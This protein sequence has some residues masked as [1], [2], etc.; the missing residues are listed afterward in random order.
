M[1]PA[2]TDWRGD[3]NDIRLSICIPV[4][5][6]GAFLGQ[7]LES[8]LGQA[9][10]EVEIVV[11]DGGSTD[12]TPGVV[13]RLQARF[14]RLRYHRL[15]KRGGI[16]RDMARCVD[17]ARGDYCWLLGGDD[18]AR[19]DA[20]PRLLEELRSGCDVYLLESMLCTFEM[21][22]IVKHDMIAAAA[23]TTFR[24]HDRQERIAYFESARNTAAFFSFCSALVVRRSR[25]DSTAVDD[26]FYGTCWAHAARIMAMIP[27][28]LTVRYLPEPFLDK[29]SDN[30]SFLTDGRTPRFGVAVDGYH[31]IADSFFGH[32]SREALCIRRALRRELPVDAWAM[33]KIEMAA[34]GRR[35]QYP[36]YYRLARKQFSDPSFRNWTSLAICHA[37]ASFFRLARRVVTAARGARARLAGP[38]P[39]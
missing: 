6:F 4:Y 32:G 14:P 28:G 22:P 39:A 31:K 9:S 2:I 38:R 20:I 13:Q 34:N 1:L 24:L 11:L 18:L 30:D 27:A 21:R 23:P 36:L 8:V 37:P 16:D 12:D 19:P 15:E 17:L 25:W 29:R 33:A 26:S 10:D 7:T 3:L 35:D 5:N